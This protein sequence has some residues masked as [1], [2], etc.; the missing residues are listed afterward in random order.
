MYQNSKVLLKEAEDL[1]LTTNK[2]QKTFIQT[3][4]QFHKHQEF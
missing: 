3:N 2:S 1:P 4:T